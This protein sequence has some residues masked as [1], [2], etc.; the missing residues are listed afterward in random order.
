MEAK[1][2]VTGTQLVSV[3]LPHRS[4]LSLGFPPL[5]LSKSFSAWGGRL[6]Q[7]RNLAS[8]PPA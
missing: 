6:W 4:L 1:V 7:N 5:R 3:C 2:K 8:T